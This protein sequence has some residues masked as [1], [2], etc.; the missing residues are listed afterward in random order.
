MASPVRGSNTLALVLVV[1]EAVRSR[2]IFNVTYLLDLAS[3]SESESPMD[4]PRTKE[5][6]LLGYSVW[7][8]SSSSA[9]IWISVLSSAKNGTPFVKVCV[10]LWE[11]VYELWKDAHWCGLA[12]SL[13]SRTRRLTQSRFAPGKT[14]KTV[15]IS[16]DPVPWIASTVSLMVCWL[17]GQINHSLFP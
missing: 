7:F 5:A 17:S 13:K 8:P 14:G 10:M 16:I 6:R 9:P 15:V 12:A 11:K 2:Q 1:E 4:L 3:A